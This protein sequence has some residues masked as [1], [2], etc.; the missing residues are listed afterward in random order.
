MFQRKKY[1][2]FALKQLKGRWFVPVIM[3]LITT[4]ILELFNIPTLV[5]MFQNDDFWTLLNYSGT[6]MTEIYSLYSSVSDGSSSWLTTIIQIMVEGIMSFACIN[7]YLKMSRSPEKVTLKSFIEGLNNWWRAILASLWRFLWVVLWSLLFFIPGIIKSIAYSQMYYILN[8][9]PE[10]SVTKAM[11]ISMIITYGHKGDLFVTYL[12]F[13]GWAILC[14][15]TL[16]IGA[17]WLEPYMQM[18]LIN[19]YHAML[20]EA[21]ESGKIKPEDLTE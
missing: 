8:E 1:K 5:R 17:L 14:C 4:I 16:G 3:T 20:K 11:R 6:D 12:S 21:I 2:K 19:A 9:Y 13:L 15:F 18:T 7:V 10:V